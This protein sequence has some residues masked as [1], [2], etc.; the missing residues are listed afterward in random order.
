VE[1]KISFIFRDENRK[2]RIISAIPYP[3]IFFQTKI[4]FVSLGMHVAEHQLYGKPFFPISGFMNRKKSA[5]N[6]NKTCIKQVPL[7]YQSSEKNTW[8]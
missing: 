5:S 2:L 6:S 1:K 7:L 8:Q 3:S 4:N